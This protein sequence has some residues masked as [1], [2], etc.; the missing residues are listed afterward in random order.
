M[1]RSSNTSPPEERANSPKTSKGRVRRG[2]RRILLWTLGG[3]AAV[4]L[5]VGAALAFVL[6]RP[7]VIREPVNK[8]L[9]GVVA[10]NLE[11]THIDSIS[12]DGFS[13]VEARLQDASGRGLVHLY[14]VSAELSWLG[15]VQEVLSSD[16]SLDVNIEELRAGH[17]HLDVSQNS[18]GEVAFIEALTPP[19]S[20]PSASSRPV[21]ISF[22]SIHLDDG[23]VHGKLADESLLDAQID[24][25]DLSLS[26]AEDLKIQDL[27]LL[28]KLRE[29]HQY[30]SPLKLQ[31]TTRIRISRRRT[32]CE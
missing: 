25:L 3:L 31:G 13:G 10:G 16:P 21:A 19:P 22:D 6:V 26:V 5:L 4:V 30:E 11:I 12:W 18:Q 23:W 7:G 14:D 29:P 15:L 17:L 24:S 28:A 20:P 27:L 32:H 8:I 2:L 1:S 9:A